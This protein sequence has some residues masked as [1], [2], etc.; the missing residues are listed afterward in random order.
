MPIPR[1]HNW[2]PQQ[3]SGM[4]LIILIRY[5]PTKNDLAGT[6]TAPVLRQAMK[7]MEKII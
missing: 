1:D 7:N 2:M 4:R 6:Q 3:K 5:C